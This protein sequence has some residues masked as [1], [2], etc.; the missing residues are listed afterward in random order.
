MAPQALADYLGQHLQVEYEVMNNLVGENFQARI[1]LLNGGRSLIPSNGWILYFFHQRMIERDMMRSQ[2]YALLANLAIKIKHINGGLFSMQPTDLFPALH[3]GSKIQILFTADGYAVARTD[4]L[5]NWY[6]D[7]EGADPRI[8][9]STAG[10]ALGF[11]MPFSSPEKWKR[12]QTDHYDPYTPE[13]RYNHNEIEDLGHAAHYI[14]PSPAEINSN[15]Q[16]KLEIDQDW[17]IVAKPEVYSQAMILSGISAIFTFCSL[18][19]SVYSKEMFLISESTGMRIQEDMP[20]SQYIHLVM[21]DTLSLPTYLYKNL[22]EAYTLHVNPTVNNI[23]IQAQT[24][25]G[26]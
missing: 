5:P 16:N 22:A 24:A 9:Q 4:I 13:V 11:V 15:Q 17:V 7:V 3:A 8:L 19:E 12:F 20:E 18:T 14:I 2:G 23:V 25:T 6:V 10:E 21:I 26:K 1:S